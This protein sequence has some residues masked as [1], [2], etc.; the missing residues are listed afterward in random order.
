MSKSI[1]INCKNHKDNYCSNLEI[2]LGKEITV[3]CLAFEHKK[4]NFD[5]V[6]E[7]SSSLVKFIL[8]LCKKCCDDLEICNICDF[9][10]TYYCDYTACE[11]GIKIWLESEVEID[12]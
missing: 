7:N 10:N 11:K 12:D 1:C 4:T 5:F 9:D 6:T 2:D 3:K 8:D